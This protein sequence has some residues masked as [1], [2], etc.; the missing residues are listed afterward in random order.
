MITS[1][2]I[3]TNQP[4]RVG[5]TGE[6]VAEMTKFGWTTIA[7]GREIDYTALLLA[8]TNQSDYEQLCRLDVLGLEDR[9][10]NDQEKVY[11]EF[12]EQLVRSQEGW[13]E[14]GLPWKGN[15]PTLLNNKTGSLQRLSSLTKRLKKSELSKAYD[16]IIN[17]QIKE[18]IVASEPPV[19]K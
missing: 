12:R 8:Q 2:L 17:G 11:A 13:Y 5:K 15:H 16:E 19:G 14:T 3:K 18:G 6:P 1:A 10:E 4:A 9:P 7:K